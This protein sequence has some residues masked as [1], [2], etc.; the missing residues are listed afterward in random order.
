MDDHDKFAIEALAAFRQRRRLQQRELADLLN[1]KLGRRYDAARVS[2]WETGAERIPRSVAN[3]IAE[4]SDC[5]TTR[6]AAESRC[7]LV[8]AVANQKG[9]V[10][11]TTSV[12][13]TGAILASRGFKVLIV[14]CDPQANATLHL[15]KNPL[16][17]ERDNAILDD[18]LLRDRPIDEVAMETEVEN[19]DLVPASI[20]MSEAE[21]SLM[22]K[23][24]GEFTLREALLPT[25]HEYDFI[26]L[27]CPP[28]MTGLTTN[29]LTAA[30]RVLIP[31]QAEAFAIAGIPYLLKKIEHTRRMVNPGLVVMGILP[32]MTAPRTVQDRES[33]VDL[34]AAFGSMTTIFP[35]VPRASIFKEAA[36]SGQPV[37]SNARSKGAVAGLTALD[38]VVRAMITEWRDN[39]TGDTNHGA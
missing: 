2:R 9:G 35:E 39:S 29:A 25:R 6:N 19:L 34:Q 17:R 11:K 7:A 3:V 15:G 24:H 30:N 20:R 26:L 18:V 21:V 5:P 13:N 33:M 16:D 4:L 28:A 14:D 8:I 10:G 32:T 22:I 23:P 37:R 31:C 27:D 1:E 36:A 12:V 38:V